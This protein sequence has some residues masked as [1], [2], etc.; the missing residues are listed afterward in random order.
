MKKIEDLRFNITEDMNN[1]IIEMLLIRQMLLENKFLTKK[2]R[3]LL[4]DHLDNLV[5]SF[6]KDFQ[7]NNVKEIEQ[8][9]ELLDK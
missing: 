2:K 3:K 1:T 6:T 5:K 4:Q 8:Y 7:E 9:H